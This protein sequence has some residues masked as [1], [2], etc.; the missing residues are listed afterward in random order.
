MTAG[1]R[2]TET[3]NG[4]KALKLTFQSVVNVILNKGVTSSMFLKENSS[5]SM[6]SALKEGRLGQ[7]KQS[8]SRQLCPSRLKGGILETDEAGQ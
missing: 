2:F 5:S 1:T 7:R 8:C 6:K 4:R 3:L